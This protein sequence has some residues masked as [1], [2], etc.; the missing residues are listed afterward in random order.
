MK[1]HK[2]STR[3][4]ANGVL[5]LTR[6]ALF[7]F[8]LIFALLVYQALIDDI[9]NN[10]RSLWVFLALWLFTSYFVL[11]RIHRLL[12]KIYIPNYYLGRVR[13]TDGLLGDPVNL[14]ITGNKQQLTDTMKAAGWHIA[15]PLSI[16]SRY[17]MAVASIF[18]RSYPTAP[19]SSLF[20]F[21][22]KQVLAFEQQI[23]GNPRKRHHVRFWPT[24]E[25]W[26]LP[27][28]YEADWLGAATYDRRVG[29]SAFTFQITHKVAVDTDQER[30]YV[31]KTLKES[32]SKT[33]VNTV[34]HFT[35]AYH[36]RNGGGDAIA[37]DGAMPF[38]ALLG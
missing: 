8:V 16:K 36:S 22:Q 37:T 10:H 26:W 5:W 21:N 19:V 6:L 4:I 11:P 14:A 3:L 9:R 30:N 23:G 38:I 35:T 27:G 12:S 28:G 33:Q 29:L 17:K 13:T 34:P 24:P 18:K 20:L 7:L 31:V 1:T 2:K 25:G 32:N 15:D